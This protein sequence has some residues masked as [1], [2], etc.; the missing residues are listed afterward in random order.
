MLIAKKRSIQ[1]ESLLLKEACFLSIC[2]KNGY[3]DH[4]ACMDED[5]NNDLSY[6]QLDHSVGILQSVVVVV[7]VEQDLEQRQ[8]NSHKEIWHSK[9]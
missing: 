8:V 3:A 6:G 7:E 2:V 5:Q 1:D 4:S 9:I